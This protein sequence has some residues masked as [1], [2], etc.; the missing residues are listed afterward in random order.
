MPLRTGLASHG[1]VHDIIIF[2]YL[3]K[4]R[5]ILLRH[6]VENRIY[7]LSFSLFFKDIVVFF[8]VLQEF[9]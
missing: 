2:L 3:I 6:P 4:R 5:T 8:I 7:D 1:P 9:A